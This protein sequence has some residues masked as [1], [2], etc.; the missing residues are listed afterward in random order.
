MTLYRMKNNIR[1]ISQLLSNVIG[2]HVSLEAVRKLGSFVS[3]L[4]YHL[5]VDRKDSIRSKCIDSVSNHREC[6]PNELLSDYNDVV[7]NISIEMF[8][9]VF[10][11]VKQICEGNNYDKNTISW[12]YQYLK[13]D[14]TNAAYG[15]IGKNGNKL[16]G[17]D[18]LVTTQFFTDDYMVKFLVDKVF[19]ENS[20]CI[21]ELVVVDP[22]C[23][24]GN[25]LTYAFEKFYDWYTANTAYNAEEIVGAILSKHI[26][27]YDLDAYLA[28]VTTLSLLAMA[29]SKVDNVNS[30]IYVFGGKKDDVLGYL[31][32][33]ILSNQIEGV[34]YNGRINS[35]YNSGMHIAYATNPPFMGSRDMS[36]MLKSYLRDNY[37]SSKAD[38]CVAFLLKMM[39]QLHAGDMIAAVSQNGWLNLSSLKQFRQELLD[40][41]SLYDCVDLGTNA[42]A[43]INGEK[44]NIVLCTIGAKSGERTSNFYNLKGVSLKEKIDRIT[45]SKTTPISINCE[46]FRQNNLCEICYELE[47]GFAQ[48]KALP[49]YGAFGKCMQGSSTGDNNTFVKYMWENV[50][51]PEDWRSVS[52]GGGYSKWHGLN[53][54]KV[55]W[56]ENAEFIKKN[57]GSAV[58]NIDLIGS[59]DFVYSDTGTL[60]LNVRLLEPQQVF[61]ASGP[62]IIAMDGNK[63]CHMGFLNSKIAT[64]LL[65]ARNPKFTISAGYISGLPI[66]NKILE[67]AAI[68]TLVKKCIDAKL[69]Y[70]SNKLPNPEFRY[71]NYALINNVE[72]YI[73][74]CISEDI[75]NDYNRYI[76]E[77]NIDTIILKA[78][79][80]SA[81]ARKQIEEKTGRKT[82][83]SRRQMHIS[84]IDQILSASL[85][86]NC[87]FQSRK[88]NGFMVGSE[89]CLEYISHELKISPKAVYDNILDNIERMALTRELYKRDLVHK[90][91]L[92]LLGIDIRRI[93]KK[94]YVDIDTLDNIF[95]KEYAAIYTKCKVSKA[96]IMDV[97]LYHH[98]KSLMG[99]PIVTIN[100]SNIIS[101]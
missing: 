100:G 36:K 45:T 80:F 85:N 66:P 56:G 23:G 17:T 84:N 44:T 79:N 61:I 53:F 94:V 58:R 37:P 68:E 2:E 59:T 22:A 88:I 78:Y 90:V 72:E 34:D 48:L 64:F 9:R 52:K 27:G 83:R 75:N 16:D 10:Q 38:L 32:Y 30:P 8:E 69:L 95:R 81:G 4:C 29:Y 3:V 33:N 43:E 97:I 31:D 76:A 93:N 6:A 28:K 71:D 41:Y 87:Q 91:L 1:K 77:R 35:V 65:K 50:E 20:Q 14:I 42:F 54:Y 24:G 25:F 19:E 49:V 47:E 70:L 86:E 11:L 40:H 18:I 21:A 15:K 96:M 63:Y 92:L 51:S 7:N 89:S 55:K 73:S 12:V 82:H 101:I 67:S 5:F 98:V 13:R 60:G 99:K 46:S 26:I 74:M 39:R 57:P 62:G